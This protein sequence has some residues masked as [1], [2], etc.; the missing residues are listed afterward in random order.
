M[1][2]ICHWEMQTSNPETARKFY[3][4]LFGWK[5]TY[6]KEMNYVMIETGGQPNGGM[7]IVK[8]IE[9]SAILLYVLVDDIEA[10]LARAG[11]LGGTTV[12]PKT[13]IPHVGYFAVIKDPEGNQIGVFTPLQ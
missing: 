11:S 2:T 8:N 4:P 3:E 10:K 5:L 13:P 6:E 12:T 9:P 7:N 1:N